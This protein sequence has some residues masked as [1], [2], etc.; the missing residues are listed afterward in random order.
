MARYSRG[1]RSDA[2]TSDGDT[3][4]IVRAGHAWR[5]V[6]AVVLGCTGEPARLLCGR[7]RGSAQQSKS[8][9]SPVV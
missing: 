3:L 9:V 1:Q 5:A 8:V 4:A 2:T 6:A 7:G